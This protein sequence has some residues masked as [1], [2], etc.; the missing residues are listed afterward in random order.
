MKKINFIGIVLMSLFM[1][2]S[3]T[4]I[5]STWKAGNIVPKHYNKILVLGLIRDAD[6]SLQEKME[7]HLVNDLKEMGYNAVSSLNEY[8]P[9]AFAGM[10]EAAAVSKLKQSGIDAVITIVLLD[11][12][13][14]KHYIPGH[15]FYSPYGYYYNRFWGYFGTLNRRID[16]PGYYV[17]DTRYFWESNFYDMEQQ[18]L[19]YSIQTRSFDPAS[20][21][22]L[23]HE[24]GQLII[25]DMVKH[26]VLLK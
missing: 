1:S 3:T 18:T 11:K 15:T 8:G 22:S 2:C 6:R 9:K 12:Q 19:V 23:G 20:S 10:E 25:G 4:K 16:E 17:T 14:E 21:E 24:Y 5:T 26:H 13:K 7:T